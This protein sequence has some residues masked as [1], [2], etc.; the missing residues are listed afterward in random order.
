MQALP[1][2]LTAGNLQ[3]DCREDIHVLGQASIVLHHGF[4]DAGTNIWFNR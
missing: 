1:A 2:Q 4:I 3:I